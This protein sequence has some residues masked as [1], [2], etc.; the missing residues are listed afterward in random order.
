MDKI[1]EYLETKGLTVEEINIV[2]GWYDKQKKDFDFFGRLVGI[3]DVLNFANLD[4]NQIKKLLV[5][6]LEILK[7]NVND[8]FKLAY[9]YKFSPYTD[10]IFDLEDKRELMHLSNY[11]RIFMRTIL[12]M[13]TGN[14]PYATPLLC[15][16]REAYGHKFDINKIIYSKFKKNVDSDEELEC[17]FNS[18]MTIG[19]VPKTIDEFINESTG[20]F[21][22]DFL[23]SK[24][25][26]RSK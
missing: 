18:S 2:C 6:N 16:N 5:N 15:N 12:Y 7:M 11:K 26:A 1:Y 19:D 13:N 3:Y 20:K 24:N 23:N 8:I 21:R 14:T 22:R 25:K 4:D 10:I 9:V 17:L